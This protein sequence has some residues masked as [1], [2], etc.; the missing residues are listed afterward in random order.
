ME[1]IMKPWYTLNVDISNAVRE[2]FNFNSL[3]TNSKFANKPIGTWSF[4]NNEINNIVTP[5]WSTYICNLLGAELTEIMIFYREAHYICPEAHVDVRSGGD[6]SIYALNWV[7]NKNDDSEMV[8]Y[9][10]PL[11]TARFKKLEENVVYRYWPLT[12]VQH[13]ELTRRSIKNIPTIVN[14]GIAHNIIVNKY[15]RWVI[16]AR[17]RFSENTKSWDDTIQFYKKF[18]NE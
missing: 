12:E 2:D 18:I 5:E 6:I 7:L 1:T 16:S 13:N 15:P 17:F 3:Y 11:S 14:V 8:W 4:T 10:A 9:D